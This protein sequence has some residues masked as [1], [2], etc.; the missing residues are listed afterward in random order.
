MRS[1][2]VD[3]SL[4]RILVTRFYLKNQTNILCGKTF[5]KRSR[6]C[7]LQKIKK[8]VSFLLFAI[9]LFVHIWIT[10]TPWLKV[11]QIL[12]T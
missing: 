9:Q 10:Y 12:Q 4:M 11:Y 8:F 2:Y 3:P 5:R 1:I 7:M 6:K